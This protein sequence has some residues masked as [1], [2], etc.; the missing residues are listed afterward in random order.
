MIAQEMIAVMYRMCKAHGIPVSNC[1]RV[2]KSTGEVLPARSIILAGTARFFVFWGSDPKAR[3]I[4]A[5]NQDGIDL[6]RILLKS[7]VELV[8]GAGIC[9]KAEYFSATGTVAQAV[10]AAQPV[11]EKKAAK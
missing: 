10:K 2:R 1:P 4:A 11:A 7:K 6:A 8:N 3:K 5:L 9:T